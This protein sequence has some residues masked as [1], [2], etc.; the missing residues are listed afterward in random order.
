MKL[1]EQE[2]PTKTPLLTFEELDIT[3]GAA[4]KVVK[5]DLKNC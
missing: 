5:H 4:Y 3:H 2:K 1:S